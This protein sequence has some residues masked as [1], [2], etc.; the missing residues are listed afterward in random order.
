[1]FPNVLQWFSLEVR[2]PYLHVEV[3]DVLAHGVRHPVEGVL[4]LV[5]TG[6]LMPQFL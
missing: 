5:Q 1:M 4:A 3:S 2:T 6:H